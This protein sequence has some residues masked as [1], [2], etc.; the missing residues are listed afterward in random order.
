MQQTKTSFGQRW[1]L[2]RWINWRITLGSIRY[3][4]VWLPTKC[5]SGDTN[6]KQINNNGPVIPEWTE[7]VVYSSVFSCWLTI[8]HIM[9]TVQRL[10]GFGNLTKWWLMSH[11]KSLIWMR[12]WHENHGAEQG[13]PCLSAAVSAPC[14][15]KPSLF[16]SWVRTGQHPGPFSAAVRE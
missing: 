15:A 6:G 13:Q 12:V 4:H 16:W 11:F 10:R 14:R 7:Q 8:R 3:Q 5:S 9:T 2:P 1:I